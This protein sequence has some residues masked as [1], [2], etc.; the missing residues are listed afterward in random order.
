M[1]WSDPEFFVTVS[2]RWFFVILW[3]V[4][5][6]GSCIIN[7]QCSNDES[8]DIDFNCCVNNSIYFNYDYKNSNDKNN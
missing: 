8:D 3:L 1:T 5:W 6:S 4:L 7:F 2:Y